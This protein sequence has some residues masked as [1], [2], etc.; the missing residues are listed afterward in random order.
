MNKESSPPPA[1]PSF[2]YPP[3]AS[4][5]AHSA[6]HSVEEHVVIPRREYEKL[7]R[8][9]SLFHKIKQEL[10]REV[11][12]SQSLFFTKSRLRKNLISIWD[13]YSTEGTNPAN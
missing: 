10:F 12:L 3:P 6:Q 4:F 2:N 1:N 9:A 8:S 7:M 5:P 13:L 11:R